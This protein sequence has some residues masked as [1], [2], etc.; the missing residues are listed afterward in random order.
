MHW[1]GRRLGPDIKGWQWGRLHPLHMEHALAVRKPLG[2]LFSI[3]AYPWSGDLETV[4][5]GVA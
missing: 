2:M 3:P 4:R 5:A 1:L